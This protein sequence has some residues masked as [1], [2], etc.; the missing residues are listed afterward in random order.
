[1]AIGPHAKPVV[2]KFMF[3]LLLI[4]DQSIHIY[5]WELSHDSMEKRQIAIG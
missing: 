3:W 1:M 5:L 4:G 2:S